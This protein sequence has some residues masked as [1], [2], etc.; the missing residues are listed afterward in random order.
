MRICVYGSLNPP[1]DPAWTDRAAEFGRQLAGRG[2]VFLFGGGGTGL[3]GTAARAAREAGG[4]LTAVVRTDQC[5]E[6]PLEGAYQRIEVSGYRERKRVMEETAD[7]FVI[8][9]G[10]IGT[11]DECVETLILESRWKPVAIYQPD[12]RYYEPLRALFRQ[13]AAE[14]LLSSDW[15]PDAWFCSTLDQLWTVLGMSSHCAEEMR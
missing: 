2:H 8:L 9:P 1:R 11:L 3:L 6:T 13:A 7:G 4:V 5:W 12:G 10:G 15:N 14:G